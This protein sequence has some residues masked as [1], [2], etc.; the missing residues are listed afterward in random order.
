MADAAA[1]DR[2]LQRLHY[3]LLADQFGEKL[4][5]IAPRDDEI[6]AGIFRR[7]RAIRRR[8]L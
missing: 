4:R 2:I 5:P 8:I 6:F 1:G 3:L 7:Q